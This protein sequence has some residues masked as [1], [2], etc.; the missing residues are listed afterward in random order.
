LN[1]GINP[2]N[3]RKSVVQQGR[4]NAPVIEIV[5]KISYSTNPRPP[6]VETPG[7]RGFAE[8]LHA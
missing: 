1:R 3:I 5:K 7:G 4:N 2:S 6:G 8:I